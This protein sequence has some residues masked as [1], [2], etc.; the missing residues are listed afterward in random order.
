MW[1]PQLV[2]GEPGRHTVSVHSE[3]S[4][5][6]W[7]I[8]RCWIGLQTRRRTSI[9]N[10]KETKILGVSITPTWIFG[11]SGHLRHKWLRYHN[12]MTNVNKLLNRRMCS[13]KYHNNQTIFI[14]YRG[15]LVRYVRLYFARYCSY[16]YRRL[17]QA[18]CAYQ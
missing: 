18:T 17:L 7:V 6:W 8:Q 5:K 14:R 9:T 3:V 13:Y 1:A 10:H 11:V 4:W 2:R 16:C 12:C 15:I